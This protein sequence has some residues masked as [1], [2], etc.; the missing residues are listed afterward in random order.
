MT[1]DLSKIRQEKKFYVLA[2]VISLLSALLILILGAT[3]KTVDVE[4]IVAFSQLLS[5]GIKIY[6]MVVTWRFCRA[7][8]MKKLWSVMNT[9]LSPVLYIFQAIYLL[10]RYVRQTG[11]RVTFFLGDRVVDA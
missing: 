4:S 9:L 11:I 2:L 7:L 8:G 10:R 5:T 1:E 6:T 3:L